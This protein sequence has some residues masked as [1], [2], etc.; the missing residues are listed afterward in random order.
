LCRSPCWLLLAEQ[1]LL[2]VWR[3]QSHEVLLVD[4]SIR[5]DMPEYHPVVSQDL[6]DE[7]A[8]VTLLWLALAAQQRDPM[9]SSTAQEALKGHLEPWLLG[10]AVVASMAVL[11][12]IRLPR[13]PAAEL[14]PE[15]EIARAGPAKR[16]IELLAVEVRSDARV[17][18]GPHV[19]DHLNA[20]GLQELRKVLKRVVGVPDRPDNR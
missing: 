14:L 3:V 4:D 19:D 11:V 13:W 1:R 10:H 12:I 6:A 18:V 20:L 15:E 2:P 5:E 9:L 17:R 7:Q 16:R 8:A